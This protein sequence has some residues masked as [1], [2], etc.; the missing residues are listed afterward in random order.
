MSTELTMLETR[1]AELKLNEESQL[2]LVM[3]EIDHPIT[4]EL[5]QVCISVQKS[6]RVMEEV[7]YYVTIH[8]ELVEG[9]STRAT[10]EDLLISLHI[11][12]S[13]I[14]PSWVKLMVNNGETIKWYVQDKVYGDVIN[15]K[16]FSGSR[17]LKN[18]YSA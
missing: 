6:W 15:D 3:K 10:K 12:E 7:I 1:L 18:I 5:A 11:H 2:D 8:P 17:L 4:C 9:F 14:D 13:K 16:R